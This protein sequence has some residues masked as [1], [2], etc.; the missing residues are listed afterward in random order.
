MIEIIVAVIIAL[1]VFKLIAMLFRQLRWPFLILCAVG[2]VL[3][4]T[5]YHLEG[6]KPVKNAPTVVAGR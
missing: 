3:Y 6:F 2:G 5:G 1:F 4:A